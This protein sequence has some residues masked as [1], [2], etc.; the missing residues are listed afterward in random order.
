MKN[1]FKILVIGIILLGCTDDNN[2]FDH[3]SKS[4][5]LLLKRTILESESYDRTVDYIYSGDKR[6]TVIYKYFYKSSGL[7]T[8]YKY[9]YEYPNENE[10][11]KYYY[12]DGELIKKRRWLKVNPNTIRWESIDINTGELLKYALFDIGKNS[13]GRDE[14]ISYDKNGVITG[15]I[16]NEYYDSNCSYYQTYYDNKG[17]ILY[18]KDQYVKDN[19]HSP[20]LDP[21]EIKFFKLNGNNVHNTIEFKQW[22]E[23]NS[24]ISS[25]KINCEYNKEGYPIF[26]ENITQYGDDPLRVFTITEHIE[27][28]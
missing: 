7:T 14:I 20:S 21:Y 1:I 6:T 4:K 26:V 22:D 25:Q 18:G 5:P 11:V 8:T 13:C 3:S 17:N 27:Y 24:L 2:L 12:K 23:N 16:I 10:F 9:K 28:Y 15:K 19:K